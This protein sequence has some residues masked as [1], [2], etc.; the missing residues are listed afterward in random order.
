[1]RFHTLKELDSSEGTVQ[2]HDNSNGN[3]VL[4][5]APNPNDPNDPLRWPRWKKHV[6][7]GSVCAFT[8]LGNFGIGLFIFPSPNVSSLLTM[9]FMKVASLRHSTPLALSLA[10]R[11][12]RPPTCSSGQSWFSGPS[13]SSTSLWPTTWANDQYSFSRLCSSA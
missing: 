7:F 10:R 3:I 4:H 2:L 8:F 6:C 9:D 13:T 12:V 5:P 11:R 1:M